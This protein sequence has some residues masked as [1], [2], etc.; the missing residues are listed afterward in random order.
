M[1]S[2]LNR[3]KSSPNASNTHR[4]RKED[5]FPA[6]DE[7]RENLR[8][9]VKQ[10][11]DDLSV[12]DEQLKQGI[13][14]QK[15]SEEQIHIRTKAMDAVADGI[16]IIDAVNPNFPFIYANQSYYKMSGYTKGEIIGKNYFLHYGPFTDSRF[17]E[18]VKQTLLQGKSF[19]GEMLQFKKNGEKYWN[20]LRITP[21]RDASG[22]ITHYVGIKTDITLMRQRD[23]EIKEQHE[24]LMHVTRVGKLA[25]FVSSLAHEISQPLTSILSYAQAA[26]RILANSTKSEVDK[27]I[28]LQEIHQSIINDDQRA[29]EVIRRLRSLLKKTTPEM[30]PLNINILI[31]ETVELI[32]TDLNVRNNVLKTEFDFNLPLVHADRI[33]LQQVLLNLISNSFDAMEKNEVPREMLIS[34]NRQ[35]AETITVSVKDS[36]SGISKENLPKLFEHFFTSKPDGL[37]MGLSISRSIV[38]AHSGHL[39]AINNPDRGAT[40]YFTLPVGQKDPHEQL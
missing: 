21:V 13:S 7:T 30:K 31:K 36:G 1:D 33:Q 9:K 15:R 18:D 26:Q 10:Q 8:S 22:T 40:F 28:L 35:D 6:I 29:S 14:K 24:E 23:L 4:R 34:T 5:L 27:V 25:E 20:L 37:G 17:L 38:E 32:T 2:I 39:D 19:F 11:T 3:Y 16:F 12:K